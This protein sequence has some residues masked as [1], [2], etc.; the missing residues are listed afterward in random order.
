M[1]W[2]TRV[3]H[4]GGL[5]DIIFDGALRDLLGTYGLVACATVIQDKLS[6]KS[7][8]YGFVEMGSEEQALHAPKTAHA[9]KA[10]ACASSSCH[11]SPSAVNR[12]PQS[13]RSPPS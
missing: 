7:T 5:T 8:D 1:L 3:A 13:R 4:V 10:M 6:R 11:S 9:F 12:C 2:D